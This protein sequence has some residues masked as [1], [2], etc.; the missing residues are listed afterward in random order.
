MKIALFLCD[1]IATG[2]MVSVSAREL[3][4]QT[5]E[6]VGLLHETG[7]AIQVTDHGE[8]VALLISV[9]QANNDGQPWTKLD[10]F[11]AEIGAHWPKGVSAANAVSEARR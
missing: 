4:Q 11:A 9:K 8:V 2:E 6:L 10:H 3:K 7:V 5:S 1:N